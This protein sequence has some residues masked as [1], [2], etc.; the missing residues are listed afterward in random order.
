[1]V[2]RVLPR[3]HARIYL[4]APGGTGPRG[5]PTWG[6]LG[7]VFPA[8]LSSGDMFLWIFLFPLGRHCN[9]SSN[10]PRFSAGSSHLA[11]QDTEL[12]GGTKASTGGWPWESVSSTES[13]TFRTC[14]L[15]KGTSGPVPF[16][17][18]P[19][20]PVPF[21]RGPSGPVSFPKGTSG[22]MPFPRGPSGPVSSPKGPSGP[23]PFPRDLRGLCALEGELW[24]LCPL[25]GDLRDL[26][27]FQG[28]LRGCVLS[29]G[30]FRAHALSKGGPLMHVG[31]AC[32]QRALGEGDSQLSG[33]S[34]PAHTL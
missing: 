8:A 27:P 23:M 16:P 32:V 22:A 33:H 3:A 20:G 25:Q 5:A 6:A 13:G 31:F 19:S 4:S 28:E 14:A 24:D 12:R 21:P 9:P 15:S 17:R 18:G 26:C 34:L 29:K 10:F 2:S 7:R 30:N 11:T 1:M